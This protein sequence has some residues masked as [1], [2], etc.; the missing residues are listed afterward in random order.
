MCE[1][2]NTDNYREDVFKMLPN[3]KFLNGEDQDGGRI[4]DI[5]VRN[6]NESPSAF[7]DYEST[8][9]AEDTLHGRNNYRNEGRSLNVEIST[10]GVQDRGT[11]GS[12]GEGGGG[13]SGGYRGSFDGRYEDRGGNGTGDRPFGNKARS[14]EFRV[15]VS[16]MPHSASWQDLKDHMK[17]AGD[18]S[19]ADD[20]E[21]AKQPSLGLKRSSLGPNTIGFEGKCEDAEV[22]GDEGQRSVYRQ[23][24]H[25]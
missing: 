7:V 2:N 11:R 9:D 4:E 1:I 21:N 12:S 23:S 19:C 18:V 14:T 20:D 13:T 17:A 3:L 6:R 5:D 15:R 16:G 22:D 10:G 24:F 8:R 25:P